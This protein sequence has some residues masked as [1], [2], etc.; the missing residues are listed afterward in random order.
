MDMGY[1]MAESRLGLRAAKGNIEAAVIHINQVIKT[2]ILRAK[3][4][5]KHPQL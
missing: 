4:I 5:N 1:G 3:N 2:L